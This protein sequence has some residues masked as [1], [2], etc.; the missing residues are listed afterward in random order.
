[1]SFGRIA[2]TRDG[3][4][5]LKVLKRRHSGELWLAV[6]TVRRGH[7]SFG[8]LLSWHEVRSVLDFAQE[9]GLAIDRPQ[10]G[11]P[12]ERLSLNSFQETLTRAEIEAAIHKTADNKEHQSTATITVLPSLPN[13]T[14]VYTCPKCG[15]HVP[16]DFSVPSDY[17]VRLRLCSNCQHVY[18][19]GRSR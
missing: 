4:L 10:S 6:D 12:G 14:Y 5:A 7:V 11:F 15:C 17:G 9:L 16:S 13:F 8:V 18:P 2:E 1:M 19:V 3:R